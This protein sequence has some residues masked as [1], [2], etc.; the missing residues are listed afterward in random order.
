LY[1]KY[2]W[3]NENKSNHS[4]NS[5]QGSFTTWRNTNNPRFLLF[6]KMAK[7]FPK[8]RENTTT[9]P[10]VKYLGIYRMLTGIIKN[11]TKR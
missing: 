3:T 5:I 7:S 11:K 1:S 9:S 6:Y 4:K 2:E 8:W 10:H